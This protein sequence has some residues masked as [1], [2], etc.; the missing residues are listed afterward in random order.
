MRVRV[1]SYSSR[2]WRRCRRSRE[3]ER[4]SQFW[5][6]Q[7]QF[8][9]G[10][11]QFYQRHISQHIV[12]QVHEAHVALPRGREH[13]DHREHDD[14]DPGRGVRG[15]LQAHQG[16]VHPESSGQTLAPRLREVRIVQEI[17]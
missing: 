1:D 7:Q 17:A 11:N 5:Q 9:N 4:E 14:H 2:F 10:S 6:Q 13:R 12:V 8:S 3:N 15:L 16:Q